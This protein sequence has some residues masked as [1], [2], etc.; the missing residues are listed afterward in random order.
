ML[1]YVNSDSHIECV[2]CLV[3]MKA[4]EEGF[5]AHKLLSITHLEQEIFQDSTAGLQGAGIM[6]SG[7]ACIALMR[8]DVIKAAQVTG[9]RDLEPGSFTLAGDL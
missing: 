7:I 3:I 1:R 4:D 5:K 2:R 9:L 8:G 6:T